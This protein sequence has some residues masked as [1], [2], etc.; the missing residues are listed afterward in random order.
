MK[1]SLI[2]LE[3]YLNMSK[4]LLTILMMIPFLGMA[5]QTY[6]P[7]DDFEQLSFELIDIL[8]RV[9]IKGEVFTNI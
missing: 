9:H 3:T 2:L 4:K 8:G 7:D 6:V 1:C 5:Q